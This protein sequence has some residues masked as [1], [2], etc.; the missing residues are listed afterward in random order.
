MTKTGVSIPLH[1]KLYLSHVNVNSG[2]YNSVLLMNFSLIGVCC[3][4]LY[5]LTQKRKQATRFVSNGL[6]VKRYIGICFFCY[7]QENYLKLGQ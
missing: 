6:F 4:G 2:L 5:V 7:I 3:L 1:L